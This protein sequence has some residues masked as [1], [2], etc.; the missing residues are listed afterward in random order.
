LEPTVREGFKRVAVASCERLLSITGQHGNDDN[1]K[2][3][4]LIHEVELDS[5]DGLMYDKDNSRPSL[6][7][8]LVQH[9][10]RLLVEE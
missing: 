2:R 3:Y 5:N 4:L 6:A 9:I 1:S 7:V 8:H 10:K